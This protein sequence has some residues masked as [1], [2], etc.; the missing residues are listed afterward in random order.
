VYVFLVLF[1]AK[2]P[3]FW[4]AHPATVDEEL[5]HDYPMVSIIDMAGAHVNLCMVAIKRHL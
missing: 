2:E 3:V 4:H 5:A 1:V